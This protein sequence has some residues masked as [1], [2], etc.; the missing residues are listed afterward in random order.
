MWVTHGLWSLRG[1]PTLAWAAHGRSPLETYLP[2]HRASPSKNMSLAIV[3]LVCI[4]LSH[5]PQWLLPFLRGVW[6]RC[7]VLACS[8]LLPSIASP[9]ACPKP[10]LICLVLEVTPATGP[11]KI[12][13]IVD[14]KL[15]KKWETDEL[16]MKE[17][18]RNDWWGKLTVPQLS[19][20]T[21]WR[22]EE[23]ICFAQASQ[24]SCEKS[25][26]HLE[27]VWFLVYE[28]SSCFLS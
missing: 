5:L 1:V 2:Q 23:T 9:A 4:I 3:S 24:N 6:V 20:V 21:A 28:N 18:M 8:G 16:E 14:Y 19:T 22:G 15:W 26:Q 10:C 12:L 25:W 11:W 27:Q 7:H 13:D 17:N